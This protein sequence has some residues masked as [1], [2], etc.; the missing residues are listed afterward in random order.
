M[1]NLHTG[2]MRRALDSSLSPTCIYL[3][4]L[5][6]S[7]TV[8]TTPKKQDQYNQAEQPYKVNMAVINLI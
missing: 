5:G 2:N 8:K 1:S 3:Q 6:D 7:D 4:S